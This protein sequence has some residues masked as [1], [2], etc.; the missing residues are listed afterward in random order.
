MIVSSVL[1]TNVLSLDITVT[2]SSVSFSTLTTSLSSL[3]GAMNCPSL[4]PSA[5]LIAYHASL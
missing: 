2:K 3:V 5:S 4:A 1:K